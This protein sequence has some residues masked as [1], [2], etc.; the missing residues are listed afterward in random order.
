LDGAEFTAC[1]SPASYRGLSVGTHT[2]FVRQKDAAG[3]V[4]TGGFVHT[5]TIEPSGPVAG[6]A[7]PRLLAKIGLTVNAKTKVT[8][9]TLKASADRSKGA[10]S[11][12]KVEYWNHAVRPSNTAAARAGFVVAYATTVKLRAN[13]VAFWVRVKDSKGKW[14][15]WY[16]TRFKPNAIGW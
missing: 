14:S 6:A 13:Q 10:N 8:T 9:L 11:V 12:T 4:N 7:A 15:G 16:R 1:T 3:N 5:W 2:F